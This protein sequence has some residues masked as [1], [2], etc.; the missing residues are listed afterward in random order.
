MGTPEF[1]VSSLKILVENGFDIVGVITATDKLAGRGNKLQQ[2]A[3][4]KYALSQGLNVLQPKNLKSPAFIEELTALKADLQVVVAFRMLPAVVFEMPPKGTINLHGSLLPQYRGAAPIN[5]A[6]INGEMETG[7]TTFFIEQKIDTGKIIFREPI[8]IGEEMNVGELHDIMKEVGATTVLKTVKAIEAD[9]YPEVDQVTLSEMEGIEEFK[10]APK[11]FK[12]DCEINWRDDTDK[13]YNFIRGLSPYPAAF[14]IL[15]GKRFKIFKT[16]KN[17]LSHNFESGKII[18]DNKEKLYISSYEGLLEIEE[19][20]MEG[21]RRMTT[22]ELLQGY[23]FS[24]TKTKSE[25]E[26]KDRG[27]DESAG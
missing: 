10:P 23:N 22:K 3:V 14:T 2:S 4:K 24:L 8:F 5:W 20:Q 25:D 11:I 15:N 17:G 26:A 18:T 13:I 21:K 6:I 19:L 1:A 9:D 27:K 16:K 12:E 7:V